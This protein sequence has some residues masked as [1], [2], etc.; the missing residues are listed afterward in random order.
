MTIL[1]F[2]AIWCPSCLMMKPRWE[3]ALSQRTGVTIVDFDYD[4]S[5]TEVRRYA[6]GTILPVAILERDGQE[7]GRIVGEKSVK[8]LQRL[9]DGWLG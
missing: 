2:S 6:V 8:E 9:L 4:E 7:I 1:R 5:E 3:K